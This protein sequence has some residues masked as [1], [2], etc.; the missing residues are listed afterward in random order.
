MG[1]SIYFQFLLHAEIQA[2]RFN[3]GL[4]GTWRQVDRINDID[5]FQTICVD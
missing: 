1:T 3:G 4:N 2:M 5:Y